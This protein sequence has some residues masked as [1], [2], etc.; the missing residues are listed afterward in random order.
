LLGIYFYPY[1]TLGL[2]AAV[3]FLFFLFAGFAIL[4][5]NRRV[6][7]PLH[8]F[9]S[10]LEDI[11]EGFII[12]EIPEDIFSKAEDDIT[13][14]FA[15]VIQ[16]NK[17][18][19]KNVDNLESGFEEER[20][21]K[22]AQLQLTRAYERFVPK[23]FLSFLQ[24]GSITEVQLG[25]HV[26]ADMTILFSDMR[27]F[28]TL[29]ETMTPEDNFRFLN[30]YLVNMEPIVKKHKGFI[31]KYIGDAIMALFQT[32][33]DEAVRA[34]I[35]MLEQLHVFNEERE[36]KGY[37]PIRIGI[38]LNTGSAMLGI[39][40]GENRM[41]GTVISDTVNLASRIEDLTKTY[42]IPL[43]IGENTYLGLDDPDA[44]CV[45]VI[46]RVTVKG[47]TEEVLIYE[48]FDADPME[49]RLAKW[50]SKPIFEAAWALFHQQQPEL[51]NPLFQRCL[52]DNPDDT[53]A[54]IYLKRCVQ[55]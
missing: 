27:A 2:F 31:D 5:L 4:L 26:Q 18:L 37:L 43:L 20:L 30:S 55:S 8:H 9:R 25:D 41:E 17:M 12:E 46:D 38:G 6:I 36:R 54:Q 14:S 13:D 28:T 33:P 32:G 39:I 34:A 35:A 45:R 51:A 11:S 50:S 53:V 49:V 24:K 3:A 44:Y 47:K 48:V 15:K 42:G 29:S 40:G 21:A 16:I 1:L 52:A 19:L 10:T 22:L 7:V 23:E